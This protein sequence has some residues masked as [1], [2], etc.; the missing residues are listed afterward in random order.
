M[1]ERKN[2]I[3]RILP[4]LAASFI[5]LCAPVT[6]S[7][8]D[9]ADKT[10]VW[11]HYTPWHTPL[12]S[13]IT[14]PNYYNYPLFRS[15]GD[16]RADW[17]EEFRQA[18]AQGIDGFLV[19]VVFSKTRDFTSY[20]DTLHEMLKAAEGSDFLVALCLDVKTTVARQVN[21]LDRMLRLFGDHPNYPRHHNKPVVATYT[22]S[23]W[24][25]D[26]WQTIRTRLHDK[27]HDIYLVAHVARSYQ[28]QTREWLATQLAN[29]DAAYAFGFRGL[30]GM[31][32]DYTA[33]LIATVADEVG[34]PWMPAMVHG[35]YGA[36]LNGRN[37][38]YQPH[39]G[40]D[41][42]HKTFELVRQGRDHWLHFTTWNDHDETSLLPMLFTTANPLLTKAYADNFKGIAPTSPLPEVCLAW[43][44]EVI[45]GTL[46]RIEAINLPSLARGPVSVKGRL[47]DRDGET[48][49]VLNTQDLNPSEFDRTE[50]LVPTSRLARSPFLV[51]E[52]TISSP[53][54]EHTTGLPP[55]L[56]VNGWQQNAVTVKVPVRQYLN[57]QNTL[58]IRATSPETI[59]AS[60]T[61][62]AGV[63]GGIAS[64][65]LFRNDRPVAPISPS[66]HGKTL[67]SLY[68]KGAQDYTITTDTGEFLNAVRK[69][70]EKTSPDFSIAP[71][72][73]ASR[74][75]QAWAPSGVLCAVRPDT[76]FTFTSP[77][78]EPLRMT[79]RELATKELLHYGN[80]QVEFFP[81][82]PTIQNHAP[83]NIRK[84]NYTVSLLS[85]A[86]RVSD[87]FYVRYETTD[88]R[89][90]LS[91]IIYPFAPKN[92]LLPA[93]VVETSINLET[94]SGAS[95]M[96]GESEYLS[97]DIPFRT[98]SIVP[99]QIPPESIR[100]GHWNFDGHG[101]DALGDM[102]VT[103]PTSRFSEQAG[104]P[105]KFLDLDGSQPVR[106]RLRTWPIGNAT[107]DFMLNPDPGPVAV[108]SIIGR[109]GWSDA[110]NIN[111]FPDGR[112]EVIRDGNETV[113]VE[114]LVSK[115]SLPFGQWSR[116]RVTNDST[117]L[118]IYINDR[119]DAEA[120]IR[121]ARSYGNS[122]WF[123]GGGYKDYANYRGKIDDLTVSG[124]AFAP[125][126]P[127]F[128]SD[129]PEHASL[130]RRP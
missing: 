11:A 72:S 5:P 14:V 95:G 129:I 27:G 42:L 119:L 83:L 100:S 16:N 58:T 17:A 65:T 99:T 12:N 62:E 20:S 122:T 10:R 50:W 40:F 55:I 81:A 52:I 111:L 115:T 86:Q 45:P 88:G 126:N 23:Q 79:A 32:R 103:I 29:A 2:N 117:C 120:P 35:Y 61:F 108:Q 25:P 76:Q 87:M 116:L 67:M 90:A 38:F 85:P 84:G 70:S 107:V 104:R 110:V 78:K 128:P 124:A 59:E 3:R 48:A 22:W 33:G 123:V 121:P 91:D 46:L 41:Q 37:D 6:S 96:K 28:K 4:I 71:G 9:V 82:D 130:P 31:P 47:L 118:R 68:L 77:G 97:K 73:L 54:F 94:S 109:R 1:T 36:W 92:R 114:K 26:E 44:R 7:A 13:S 69:F 74:R 125:G 113:P 102:P 8:E 105:G 101:R 18:K 30:D 43:H 60:V 63:A 93:T 66:T 15:T 53:G 75:A 127:A 112:V 57:L 19:D 49:A 56:L 21:E 89:V 64:A 98:P 24:T 80:L 39:Q 106:M 51:P 34:K